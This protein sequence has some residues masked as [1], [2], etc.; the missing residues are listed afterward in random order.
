MGM[1]FFA[2]YFLHSLNSSPA[3]PP[4]NSLL[5]FHSL[6]S[7]ASYPPIWGDTFVGIVNYATNT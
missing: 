3:P 5:L 4:I 2:V 1:L 7:T 6:R